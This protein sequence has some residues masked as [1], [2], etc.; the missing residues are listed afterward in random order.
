MGREGCRREGRSIY[1]NF[2][3]LDWGVG[4]SRYFNPPSPSVHKADIIDYQG[5]GQ[6]DPTFKI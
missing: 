4:V 5:R 2:S 3:R 6:P 1:C